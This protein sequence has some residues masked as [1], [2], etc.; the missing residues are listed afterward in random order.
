MMDS[1]NLQV[2]MVSEMRRKSLMLVAALALMASTGGLLAHLRAHQ[3]LGQ[4]GVKTRPLDEQR[5]EVL[6]PEEVADYTS[7]EKSV[8]DT[9][10]GTLPKDTSFGQRL[11][12]APDGF[13]ARINVVLM[14]SD[15]TSLHK[16][17]FCV[18]GQGW[19]IDSSQKDVVRMTRPRAYDLPVTELRLS[20]EKPGTYDGLHGVYVY[21]FVADGEYT[22]EHWQR[23]WWMAR[24]LMRTGVLQRWAYINYFAPCLPGQEQATFERIKKLIAATA[25]D[26]QL[27]PK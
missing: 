2:Y 1:E 15:R 9:T 26:F 19:R 10:R 23:M 14:G 12:Q 7:Q 8:D 22:R 20:E 13:R 6:L 27:T 16:P 25:P 17:Q 24:D 11:Y 21:W 18:R 5:L 3:K 4:P